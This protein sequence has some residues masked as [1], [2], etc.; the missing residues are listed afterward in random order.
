MSAMPG[1]LAVAVLWLPAAVSAPSE[2]W[3]DTG[4]GIELVRPA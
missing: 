1:L 2:R 4:T 3:I